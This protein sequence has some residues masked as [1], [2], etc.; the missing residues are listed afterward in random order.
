MTTAPFPQFLGDRRVRTPLETA[1]EEAVVLVDQREPAE[2]EEAKVQQKQPPGQPRT[3][4][5][6]RALVGG[7]VG[8]LP[9][10][11]RLLGDVVDEIERQPRLAGVGRF[12]L[13]EEPA[14]PNDGCVYSDDVA[15]LLEGRSEGV[16]SATS[17][18]AWSRR[19]RRSVASSSVKRS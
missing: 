5:E 6:Q 1:N 14:Q 10:D 3:G 16:G 4:F 9:G 19:S 18:T 15:E 12:E 13:R 7:L 11:H 17:S 8:D 2:L